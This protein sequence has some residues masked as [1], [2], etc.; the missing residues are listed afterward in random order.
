[1]EPKIIINLM[2]VHFKKDPMKRSH[3]NIKLFY[4]VLYGPQV[5]FKKSNW[6]EV[7]D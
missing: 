2:Q 7:I 6:K 4:F 5:D 3:L 1:M